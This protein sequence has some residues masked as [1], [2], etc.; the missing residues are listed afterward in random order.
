MVRQLGNG[1]CALVSCEPVPRLYACMWSRPGS[2][3]TERHYQEQ[4]SE[5]TS[6]G[7]V[8]INPWVDRRIYRESVVRYSGPT[9]AT[10]RLTN[11]QGRI[12][13]CELTVRRCRVIWDGGNAFWMNWLRNTND[14]GINIQ[15][16]VDG[17]ICGAHE[18]QSLRW[19]GDTYRCR[20]LGKPLASVLRPSSLERIERPSGKVRGGGKLPH[21]GE[22]IIT[23][24][25]GVDQKNAHIF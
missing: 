21:L 22:H 13:K 7:R 3:L 14:R 2:Q 15:V 25:P 12:T 24:Q 9:S 5:F 11:D 1:R 8:D 20:M 4:S 16:R 6:D 10:R 17:G 19:R 18:H 23:R